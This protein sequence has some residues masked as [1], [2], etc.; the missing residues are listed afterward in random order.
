M[1]IGLFA[2]PRPMNVIGKLW[3]PAQICAEGCE[4]ENFTQ[5]LWKYSVN[6]AQTFCRYFTNF[7]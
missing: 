3:K 6:I 1:N 7:V 2:I 5:I 4:G